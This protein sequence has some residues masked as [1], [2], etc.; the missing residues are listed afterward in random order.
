[1]RR[2]K[3]R[4]VLYV[5]QLLEEHL[6]FDEPP[7]LI[8]R[9]NDQGRQCIR[10]EGISNKINWL[11]DIYGKHFF[12]VLIPPRGAVTFDSTTSLILFLKS[13]FNRGYDDK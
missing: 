8:V 10:C 12:Y 6:T 3:E 1:M 13:V 11:V 7:K 2:V 5:M 4:D 9:V